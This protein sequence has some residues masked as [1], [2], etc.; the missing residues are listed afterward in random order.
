MRRIVELN[1]ERVR[2]ELTDAR[3]Y[4]DMFDEVVEPSDFNELRRGALSS[5]MRNVRDLG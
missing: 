5:R 2:L 3:P 4:H 1:A